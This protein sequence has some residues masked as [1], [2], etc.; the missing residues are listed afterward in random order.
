MKPEQKQ[1][2]RSYF[3]HSHC[4]FSI[5]NLQPCSHLFRF[6]PEPSHR[7]HTAMLVC[8]FKSAQN[9]CFIHRWNRYKN[10]YFTLFQ[11]RVDHSA[12]MLQ[13]C[14]GFPNPHSHRHFGNIIAFKTQQTSALMFKHLFLNFISVLKRVKIALPIVVFQSINIY[15][16]QIKRATLM[17]TM[18]NSANENYQKIKI[19]ATESIKFATNDLIIPSET[20]PYLKL[21]ISP[22]QVSKRQ[23]KR[24]I[25]SKCGL[26]S[27]SRY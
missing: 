13:S 3:R 25:E 6:S 14:S 7:L 26:Q 16:L 5:T 9:P 2:D 12:S 22:T 17:Q 8:N 18:P 19:P 15:L 20:S 1:F 4:Q 24:F 23:L 21:N 10:S 11:I 27:C